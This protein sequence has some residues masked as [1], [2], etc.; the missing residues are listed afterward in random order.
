MAADQHARTNTQHK[1]H[2]NGE[3]AKENDATF[4]CDS[5]IMKLPL[6]FNTNLFADYASRLEMAYHT[7]L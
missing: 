7:C 4:F 3:N 5:P 6:C 2:N 1:K